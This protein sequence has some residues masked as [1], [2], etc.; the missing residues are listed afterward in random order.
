VTR[1]SGFALPAVLGALIVMAM[2]VAVGAQRALLAARDGALAE[3]RVQLAAAAETALADALSRNADTLALRATP[4]GGVLDSGVATVGTAAAR[5]RL[6]VV[7]APVAL[8]SIDA[9]TPVREGTA[10]VSWRL[11]LRPRADTAGVPAW[12]PGGSGW[13]AQLPVP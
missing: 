3:A 11:W 2:L 12:A 7:L 1:R 5:W 8:L 10:R 13:R 6:S 4:T 9:S